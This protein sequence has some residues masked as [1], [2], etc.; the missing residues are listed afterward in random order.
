MYT[1]VKYA[2]EKIFIYRVM[3]FSHK[4]E[5]KLVIF[6]NM[7]VVEGHCVRQNMSNTEMQIPNDFS[8]LWKLKKLISKWNKIIIRR[9]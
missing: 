8:C 4:K 5:L 7:D 9:D 2:I 3:L 1:P 6:R